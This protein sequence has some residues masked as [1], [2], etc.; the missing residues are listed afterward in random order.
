MTKK[1]IKLSPKHG[2]NPTML[3]AF[4]VEKPMV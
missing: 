2:I 4:A 3:H 1:S